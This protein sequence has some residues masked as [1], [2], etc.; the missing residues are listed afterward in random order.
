[1][2]TQVIPALLLAALAAPLAWADNVTVHG[3]TGMLE[4]QMIDKLTL[5]PIGIVK[6]WSVRWR[7]RP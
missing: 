6:V 4:A 7:L 5:E 3:T 2:R 1:M